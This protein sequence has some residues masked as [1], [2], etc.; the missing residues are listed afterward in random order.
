MPHYADQQISGHPK[1]KPLVNPSASAPG[2]DPF[3]DYY[4]KQSI[5]AESM[6]R[7]DGVYRLAQRFRSAQQLPT[8]ALDVL[9]IGCNAGTQ[10]CM[11]AERGHVVH[12]LEINEPLLEIARQRS[13]E[14]RHEID[15]QVGTATRM[16]WPNATMDVCLMPE[17][18]EHIDDWR[19]CLREAGRVLRPGGTLYVST[20]NKLCPKQMEFEL[21]LYSWY[22]QSLKKRYER[23]ATTTR[24]ELANHAQY[25]AVNWFSPYQLRR[26]I[27]ALGFKA[28]DH[29]E[30]IDPR[31]SGSWRAIA[32]RLVQNLALARWL[33][34]VVTPYSVVLATRC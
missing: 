18:L 29:F 16:P 27:A 17:L 7:F 26:D 33:V 5:S 34:H 22:P 25:P 24:P 15:F 31:G 9:D 12:G 21:P 23:L 14:Q 13:R 6:A 30:W 28:W 32:L 20:T 10:A 19:Q 11:W 4:E 3:V 2:R 8:E 1:M